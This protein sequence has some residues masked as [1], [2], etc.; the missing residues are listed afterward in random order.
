MFFLDDNVQHTAYDSRIFNEA[1]C[2]TVKRN[3]VARTVVLGG[4][5]GQTLLSLLESSTI[6]H[7]TI[8]EIDPMVIE[9]CRK[10]VKGVDN[11]FKDTR[12]RIII[13]DAFKHIHSMHDEFDAAVIDFTEKPFGIRSNSAMLMQLYADIKEKCQGRC[14]QY[15]GSSVDLTY[16][17]RLR[18]TVDRISKH[19]LSNVRYE[20]CFIPSFGAPHIFMHAGYAR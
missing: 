14:S 17:P 13:G 2:G 3:A 11:A 5:S 1:L 16:G 20:R 8:I 6:T 12:T 19:F 10:Y 18:K 9:C 15:I 7:V 4:G